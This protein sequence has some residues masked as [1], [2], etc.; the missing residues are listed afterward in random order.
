ME[1]SRRSGTVDR[2]LTVLLTTSALVVTGVVVHRE[3][4][5]RADAGTRELPTE[6]VFVEGWE[7]LLAAG[8]EMR[9]PLGKLRIVQFADLQCPFCAR[10]EQ[11]VL[12]V[13]LDEFESPVS[14]TFVHLP[15]SIHRFAMPAAHAAECA[16]DQNRFSEYVHA[17]YAKQ[18][19]LGLRTWWDY[20]LDAGVPDSTRFERCVRGELPKRIR[21]GTAWAE[22]LGIQGTPTVL[23]EGWRLPVAPRTV[24][25]LHDALRRY[26]SGDASEEAMT[27][28][29]RAAGDP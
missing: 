5:P 2:V 14:V 3:V 27:G 17:I 29:G 8:I 1:P 16:S 4:S 11:T 12:T 6:S 23:I 28:H 19:S 26:R 21:E 10:F 20:A 7:S 22:D 25:E 24:S 13:G 9:D 18:D 15:L